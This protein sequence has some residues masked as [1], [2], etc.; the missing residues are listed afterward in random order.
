MEELVS[1]KCG[2]KLYSICLCYYSNR[3]EKSAA[4]AK[5]KIA[6]EV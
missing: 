5:G 3:E 2:N 4:D 1:L 6:A